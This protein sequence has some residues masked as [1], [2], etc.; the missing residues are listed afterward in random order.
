MNTII[1][2]I[3]IWTTAQKL[4]TSGRGRSATNQSLHGINKLRGLILDLAIQGKLIPQ[5]PNDEQASV[6]LKKIAK[7]EKGLIKEKKI[8]KP[9]VLSEIG[10]DEIPF[11]LPK[12]WQF[13]RLNNI[14]EWGAGATPNRGNP[15]YYGGDIPWFKSGELIGQYISECEEYVTEL[16][17]TKASLRYNKVGDVLI[18]MY[19]AT[20]GKTSILAIPATT[21]QAV[22]ACTPFSGIYNVFLLTL[23]QAYK[24]R[25]IGMGAGGAQ[26]NISREKI[27]ATVIALPPL[28]EQHR[29]VFKVDELMALCDQLEQQQTDSNSAHEILVE[30][31][32]DTLTNA[33]DQA[34]LETAWQRISSHFKTLF[35][36]EHSIDRL[37]QT[38]LQLAVMGKLVPQNPDDEP[39]S[40]L[41]KKIAKEKGRLVKEGKIRKQN[42]LAKIEEDEMI[43]G[44]P[45]SW[46]VSRLGTFTIVG[47]G[48]TPSREKMQYYSPQEFNWVSSGE[49]SQDFIYDTNEKISSLALKETNVSIYPKGTLIVAMYGQGKTRGQVSELM[50][51]AGTNQACAAVVFINKEEAHRKYLKYF[52]KKAYDEIRSHSAGGAQPNLNLGKVAN[53]VIPIP[54]LAEQHRIVAKVDELFAICDA[55]KERINESQVTQLNLADALVDGAVG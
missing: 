43:F 22:C 29:I 8:K 50:I 40:V 16:A 9:K 30:T 51:E 25:F 48:S 11:S 47:T 38:I 18:A 19:G 42:P 5:D 6:L 32:L 20:I 2:T 37:K 12:G 24:S 53:T 17:L 28:A 45:E 46:E 34:E 35:T 14:G 10:N 3:S 36:T 26:P 31:L 15:E 23:L 39:A 41:L 55:L 54:P 33:P 52:F 27:I 44:L 13:T 49:T 7:E 4:K 1:D 21:N